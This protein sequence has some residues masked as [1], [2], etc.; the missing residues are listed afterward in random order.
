MST[1]TEIPKVLRSD[2]VIIASL[3]VN[4]AAQSFIHVP[5]PSITHWYEL[6]CCA[7]AVKLICDLIVDF[8]MHVTKY[9]YSKKRMLLK[10]FYF[11]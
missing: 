5:R 1:V 7:A 2:R 4:G 9:A 11:H 6:V 3:H 8:K 10:C